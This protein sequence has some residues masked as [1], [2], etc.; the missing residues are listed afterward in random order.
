MD[1]GSRTPTAPL[2][3]TIAVETGTADRTLILLHGSDGGERDLLPLAGRLAS[4]AAVIA[5]RG[6]VETPQGRAHFDRRADRGFADEDVLVRV[7]PLVDA[8]R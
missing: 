5:P 3:V 7:K 8:I 1:P 6:A 2:G 4:G